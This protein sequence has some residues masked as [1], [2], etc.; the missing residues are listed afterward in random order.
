MSRHQRRLRRCHRRRRRP[1]CAIKVD[2]TSQL[3]WGH[4]LANFHK[5]KVIFVFC[6][7][8]SFAIFA[9]AATQSSSSPSLSSSS[10]LLLLLTSSS[11]SSLS[12][13]SSS[14][15][16]LTLSSSLTLWTSSLSPTSFSPFPPVSFV[17]PSQP[18]PIQAFSIFH[19]LDG[20]SKMSSADFWARF[21]P[22]VTKKF[23]ATTTPIVIFHLSCNFFAAK[24]Q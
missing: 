20:L 6:K 19:H 23:V 8:M 15:S 1:G 14:S 2:L 13:T 16:L 17:S 24:S 7:E 21:R 11:S 9:A 18:R 12:L 5:S 22:L 4:R 3:S 10:S